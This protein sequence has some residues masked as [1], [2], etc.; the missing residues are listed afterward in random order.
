MAVSICP[1]CHEWS[2]YDSR[3]ELEVVA[4]D[5]AVIV[6]DGGPL[7]FLSHQRVIHTCPIRP[8]GGPQ[9]AAVVELGL[10]P[11]P[12]DIVHPSS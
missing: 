6:P 2:R 8:A 10:R 4:G 12:R 1:S 5:A 3:E 11:N 9:S 7:T